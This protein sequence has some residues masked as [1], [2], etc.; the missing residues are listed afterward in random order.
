M[1]DSDEELLDIVDRLDN[2]TGIT[3]KKQAH[4][5]GYIHRVVAIYVLS[6]DGKLYVQRVGKNKLYDHS[7]GGHVSRGETYEEAAKREVREE[8]GLLQPLV[9]LGKI[10]SDEVDRHPNYRHIYAI[11]KCE[12]RAGWKFVP[13]EEV[14][15]IEALPIKQVVGLMK[16][17]S[18]LFTT[19][20]L[21]TMEY[22]LSDAIRR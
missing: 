18:S 7:V 8:L 10:Y 19:G 16:T 13:N 5:K 4:N 2:V 20:F 14:K 17:R 9:S 22:Y 21:R 12:A 11:Y 15:D 3:T 6:I 1:A